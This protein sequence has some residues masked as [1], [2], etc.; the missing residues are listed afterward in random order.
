MDTV[1]AGLKWQTCLVYLDDVV[2]FASSFDEHLRRLEAVLEAIKT[3]GLTLKPE[4]CRFA[5]EE[6]LF[7]GHVISRDGVRP[8][9]RKTAAI[10]GFPKPTD[11]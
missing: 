8:D 3:S 5:Y 10:A 6:L 7:L 9:P 11:T 4:K 2:V 1:L